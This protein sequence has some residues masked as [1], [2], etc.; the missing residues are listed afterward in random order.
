MTLEYTL[1]TNSVEVTVLPV[2]IEEQSIPYENCYVWVYN[3]KIKNKGSSSIQL[4]SRHWQIIDYKG[5][6]N[7]IAGVG[8]I[9]EQPVIKPGEIFKYTSGTYLNAPSGIMQG[10]YEFLNE[11]STKTFEV[12]IPPFSL[13]S[14]YTNIRS[15]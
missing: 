12:M 14:P 5:K 15:H 13:D 10:K 6:V 11:E 9:G 7:E 8:V 1:T 2:Y 4:L 3:V